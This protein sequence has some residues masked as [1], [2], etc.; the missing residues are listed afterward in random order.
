VACLND[1]FTSLAWEGYWMALTIAEGFALIGEPAE[2]LRW[3]ERAVEKGWINYPFLSRIDPWL[4]AVR[5]DPRFERLM[6][7]VRREW[8]AF[9]V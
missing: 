1:R 9:E 4:E 5:G 8:E 3:L 2:S 7:R 6:A